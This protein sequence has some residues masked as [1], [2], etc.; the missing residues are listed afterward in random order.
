MAPSIIHNDAALR[1]VFLPGQIFV[2]GGFIL[3]ANS[4][5]HLEQIDSYAPGHQ[6][7]FGS[8]YFVADIHG[9][10][11]FDGFEP[12][13]AA[14][15][16]SD[17]HDLNLSSDHTREIAPVTAL[18]LDPEQIAP[19]EDGKLNPAIEA[20]DSAASEPH[21]DPT[22]NGICVTGTSDS[23]PV[24]GSEPHA[25]AP[26]ELDRAPTV[27][28]SSADIFRHSPLGDVLN[29]L[30]TLSLVGH[31]QLNYI[32]FELEADDGEFC[33]PPT[34]HFIATVE[35]LTDMLDYDSEDIDGMDD[36]AGE[37]QAQN[38]PFTG[39]WI[40]TSSYEM[41]LVDTP[42]ENNDY[43][44]K[45]PVED[46]PPETQPKRRRQRH[47]SKSR[48]GKD[49]NTGTREINTPND[50]EDKEDPIEPTSK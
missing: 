30:K 45:D 10:L 22:L 2:F 28:F 26:I 13:A 41:Y 49:S 24:T 17:E 46:K 15:C 8:L 9:D 48:C 35:D 11:F 40:A 42:N 50:A 19:P 47:R 1:E 32:R 36:D 5:G 21:T 7:R 16:H 43:N 6:V 37:G 29:S 18:A 38:S 4:L 39:R 3:W 20:V 12:M 27:E 14:P 25:S 34:S 23:S 33:F 31:S 44:K